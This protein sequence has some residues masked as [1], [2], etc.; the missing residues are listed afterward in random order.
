MEQ[1]QCH[2]QTLSQR[3]NSSELAHVLGTLAAPRVDFAVQELH[4]HRVQKKTQAD[5]GTWG[6]LELD[7]PADVELWMM[8]Y[9]LLWTALI[10]LGVV[11][12]G[13]S[14]TRRTQE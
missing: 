10:M 5:G 7:G 1:S 14:C 6:H 13:T 8:S 3:Q 4:G 9:N 12:S 2:H 11:A